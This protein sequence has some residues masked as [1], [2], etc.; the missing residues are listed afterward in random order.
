DYQRTVTPDAV[1]GAPLCTV[2]AKILQSASVPLLK[3]SHEPKT[4]TGIRFSRR[5]NLRAAT[6]ERGFRAFSRRAG[7][8]KIDHPRG[9]RKACLF[10]GNEAGASLQRH[11]AP[12][13]EPLRKQIAGMGRILSFFVYFIQG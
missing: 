12:P 9:S 5:K 13:S 10:F 7:R 6:S 8:R 2:M 4:S 1:H 3:G 11:W